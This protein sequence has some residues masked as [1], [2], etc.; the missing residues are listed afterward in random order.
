MK[1]EIKH[2]FVYDTSDKELWRDF[3]EWQDDHPLTFEALKEFL[4]DQFINPN[5]DMRGHTSFEILE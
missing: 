1:I 3:L 4:I 5:F 2:S